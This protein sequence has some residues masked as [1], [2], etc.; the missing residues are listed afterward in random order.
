MK[1]ITIIGNGYMAYHI[2][3]GLKNNYNIEIVSRKRKDIFKSI[4]RYESE[5]DH[6]DITEKII[7]LCIKPD[8]VEKVKLHGKSKY[9]ISILAGT[10]IEK[11]EKIIDSKYYT[12]AMPNIACSK[13]QSM[14]TLSGYKDN[15][16]NDLFKILGETLWIEEEK[17]N[18]STAISG[19]GL[20]YLAFISKS[21]IEKGIENGLTEKESTM[22]SKQLFKGFSQLIDTKS[23]EEIIKAVMSPKGTTEAGIN[24]L[25]ENKLDKIIKEGI[26][27]ASKRY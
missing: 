21:I 15:K 1:T 18:I 26:E 6:Y 22:L 8:A 17:M 25:K 20:A 3:K 24:S 10:K 7:I 12:R 11:L 23:N 13:N 27:K 9:L 2:A 16:I 19:S 5:L 14:T 4:S